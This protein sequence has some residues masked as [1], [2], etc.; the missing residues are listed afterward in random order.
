MARQKLTPTKPATTAEPAPDTGW[1]AELTD[2]LF[3]LTK[4]HDRSIMVLTD[5]ALALVGCAIMLIAWGEVAGYYPAIVAA[6]ALTVLAALATVPYFGYYL[7]ANVRD[8]VRWW[9]ARRRN[10]GGITAA[11]A[12]RK[13]APWFLE[14]GDT[15]YHRCRLAHRVLYGAGIII[16]AALAGLYLGRYAGVYY[17]EIGGAAAFGLGGIA[18]AAASV[19]LVVVLIRG[20]ALWRSDRTR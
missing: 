5:L 13:A 16:V 18:W 12:S 9:V 14:L 4:T 11:P 3:E 7:W 15:L 20:A 2:V 8:V 17:L 1:F 10:G 19:Y 6:M